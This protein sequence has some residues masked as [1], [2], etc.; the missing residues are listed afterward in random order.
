MSFV[1]PA[2]GATIPSSTK[3]CP[4][5]GT[6]LQVVPAAPA[7]TPTVNLLGTAR[8]DVA[9]A[10]ADPLMG[11]I[12]DGRYKIGV[13]LG[14][15]GVGSVYEGEHVEMGKRVA[16]KTLHGALAR[17]EEFLRRFEREARALSKLSHP[18]CVSVLDYGRVQKLEPDRDIEKVRNMPYLVMEDRKSVV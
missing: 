18:G 2:C 15:G 8:T 4:H 13:P 9:V 10:V 17:T 1:C 6:P 12:I 14:V 16:V 11:T 5:D 7:T 3:F